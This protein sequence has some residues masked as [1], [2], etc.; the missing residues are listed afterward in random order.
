MKNNKA[1][2]IVIFLLIS[3]CVLSPEQAQA[4]DM[5]VKAAELRKLSAAVES[6][7]RFKDPSPMLT[8]EELL[9]LATTHNSALLTSFAGFKL[10][11]DRRDRHAV[12]LVCS[13][14][15]DKALLEDAACTGPLDVHHWQSKKPMPCEF[16]IQAAAVC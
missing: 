8:D 6:T 16:T 5:Y 1:I 7:V 10:R 13:P 15:G 9:K 2:I 12:V 11:M 4:D 3:G 14:S